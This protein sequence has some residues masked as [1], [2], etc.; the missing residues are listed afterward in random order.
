MEWKDRQSKPLSVIAFHC[1][2]KIV[3]KHKKI[4]QFVIAAKV[5]KKRELVVRFVH[6][7]AF[8]DLVK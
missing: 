8:F 4:G 5:G 6:A 7:T 2:S 3:S 1:C